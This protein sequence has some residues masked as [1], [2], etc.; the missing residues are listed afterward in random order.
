M[1][2]S[3]L[4]RIA[5]ATL[6]RLWPAGAQRP[7]PSGAAP[8]LLGLTWIGY[9]AGAVLGTLLLHLVAWP[10]LAP[11]VLLLVVIGLSSPAPS[12]AD[13]VPHL[14]PCGQ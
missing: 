3:T 2:T 13:R 6:D 7:L 1:V 14:G 12:D 8:S 4:A 11:A 5:D 10:L 9:L